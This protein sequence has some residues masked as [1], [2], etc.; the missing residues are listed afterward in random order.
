MQIAVRYND[1]VIGSSPP[2]LL[3][4]LDVLYGSIF[5]RILLGNEPT[6]VRQCYY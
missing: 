3:L 1:F 5:Q 2:I 4:L 6:G